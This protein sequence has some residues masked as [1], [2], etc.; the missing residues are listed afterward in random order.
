MSQPYGEALQYYGYM[1][2]NLRFNAQTGNWDP[3]ANPVSTEG[4]WGT[5]ALSNWVQDSVANPNVS[6][7][8][9]WYVQQ[10]GGSSAPPGGLETWDASPWG[11]SGNANTNWTIGLGGNS[12]GALSNEP[13]GGGLGGSGANVA[14]AGVDVGNWLGNWARQ[15]FQAPADRGI[16][17]WDATPDI[18]TWDAT[19]NSPAETTVWSG[20]VLNWVPAGGTWGTPGPRFRLRSGGLSSKRVAVPATDIQSRHAELGHI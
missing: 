3:T 18:S 13:I 12:G 7:G 10:I 1:P 6:E 2:S 17:V 20:D 4:P 5:A 11:T 9:R 19:V 8:Q 14:T 15:Y 16:D